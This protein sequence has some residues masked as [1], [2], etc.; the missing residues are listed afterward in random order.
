MLYFLLLILFSISLQAITLAQVFSWISGYVL[1]MS[2]VN[3]FLPPWEWFA[4]YPRFQSVYKLFVKIVAFWGAID[5]KSKIYPQIGQQ[6]T[7]SAAVNNYAGREVHPTVDG[8]VDP[9][10]KN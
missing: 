10:K 8:A 1:I 6:A 5:I 9:T 2:L 3:A 7:A 4:D